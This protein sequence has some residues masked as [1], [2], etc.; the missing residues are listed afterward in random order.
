M[1]E[2]KRPIE[3]KIYPSYS[4]T[5]DLDDGKKATFDMTF[6][7]DAI[8]RVEEKTGL[9]LLEKSILA[10]LLSLRVLSAAFWGSVCENHPEYESDEGLRSLRSLLNDP[11][12]LA[13]VSEALWESYLLCLP[14]KRREALLRLREEG[15]KEDPIGPSKPMSASTETSDGSGLQPSQDSSSD[16]ALAS[17]AS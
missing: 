17:S 3:R 7:F 14:K 4:I 2:K 13:K 5:L 9:K 11:E 8:I 12:N 1:P 15:P 10:E 16:S 6:N